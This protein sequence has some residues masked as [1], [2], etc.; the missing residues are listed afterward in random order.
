MIRHTKLRC[1]KPAVPKFRVVPVLPLYDRE[2]VGRGVPPVKV[3]GLSGLL[4]QISYVVISVP[5]QLFAAGTVR[6]LVEQGF[7]KEV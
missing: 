5:L 4:H 2:T 6:N 1:V 7:E 3:I